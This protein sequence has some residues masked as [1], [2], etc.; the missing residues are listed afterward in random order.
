MQH[1]VIE[2]VNN[3]LEPVAQCVPTITGL[4]WAITTSLCPFGLWGQLESEPWLPSIASQATLAAPAALPPDFFGFLA[5]T[6]ARNKGQ[7][8]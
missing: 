5:E 3:A 4:P 6:T 2:P 8:V 7:R 1:L